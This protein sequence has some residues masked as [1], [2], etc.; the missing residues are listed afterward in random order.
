MNDCQQTYLHDILWVHEM[1]PDMLYQ[2]SNESLEVGPCI[3]KR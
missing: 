1:Q 3:N 2:W